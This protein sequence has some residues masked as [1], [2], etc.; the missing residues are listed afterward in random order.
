MEYRVTLR[1]SLLICVAANVGIILLG[2][3]VLKIF[4]DAYAANARTAL[5]VMCLGGLGLIVKDHHVTLARVTNTVGREA[6]LIGTL[7]VG[8]I[9]G[10]AIGAKLGGL[11]GLALGWVAAVALEV[12]VCG[13]LVWRAYRGRI[14]MKTPLTNTDEQDAAAES[15]Q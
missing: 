3:L 7:S 5:I 14:T 6:V 2:G 4:G 11:T 10:A 9:A 15:P 8:E 12:V 13:P 1:Y